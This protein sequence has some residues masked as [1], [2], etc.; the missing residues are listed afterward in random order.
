[1]LLHFVNVGS[2]K[3]ISFNSECLLIVRTFSPLQERIYYCYNLVQGVEIGKISTPKS[4]VSP[5][6]SSTCL[7]DVLGISSSLTPGAGAKRR[8]TYNGSD[9]SSKRMR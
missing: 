1:M 6:L 8:L 9:H 3:E 5:N 7:L 2:D 4:D